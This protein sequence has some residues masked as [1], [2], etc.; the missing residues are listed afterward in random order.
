MSV[1]VEALVRC[2]LYL[3]SPID[4]FIIRIIQHRQCWIVF[5]VRFYTARPA[6]HFSHSWFCL[7][8]SFK[9]QLLHSF[10]SQMQAGKVTITFLT[11]QEVSS[12]DT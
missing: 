1:S 7:L 8:L 10:Y 9:L 4:D 11:G 6:T 2:I 12:S 5:E 3:Y